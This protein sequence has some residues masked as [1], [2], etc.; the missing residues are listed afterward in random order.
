MC[1]NTD[2][3]HHKSFVADYKRSGFIRTRLAVSVFTH[4][5]SKKIVY[6]LSIIDDVGVKTEMIA[7][8]AINTAV[9]VFT[10]TQYIRE[11]HALAQK[12]LQA[13]ELKTG[14]PTI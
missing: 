12:T 7:I 3:F 9:S 13:R 2:R 14:V 11:I 8:S 5:I 4:D 1:V 6:T 10:I